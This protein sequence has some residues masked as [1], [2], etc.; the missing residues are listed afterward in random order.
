[1]KLMYILS[2]DS[3]MGR[4]TEMISRSTDNNEN[5]G[6]SSRLQSFQ[7]GMCQAFSNV[8]YMSFLQSICCCIIARLYY[9]R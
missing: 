4:A 5:I 9:G 6:D 3:D 8:I 1:M 2:T 7:I